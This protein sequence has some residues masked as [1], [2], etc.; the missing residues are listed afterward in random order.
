VP[1]GSRNPYSPPA[2][3]VGPEDR[4]EP[5]PGVLRL[6]ALL[7]GASYLLFY[8]LIPPMRPIS[9]TLAMP[10]GNAKAAV[11][12]ANAASTYL[13]MGLLALGFGA[14]LW[15]LFK[16]LKGRSWARIT[17]TLLIVAVLVYF[18]EV[19]H[20]YSTGSRAHWIAWLADAALELVALALFFTPTAS[21]WY[22][23]TTRRM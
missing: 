13:G 10:A 8:F 7:F 3:P 22:R 23:A 20:T 4:H 11:E 19:A 1:N 9:V 6:A 5:V 15:L 21:R 2:A 18:L 17:L 12:T 14:P 16:A